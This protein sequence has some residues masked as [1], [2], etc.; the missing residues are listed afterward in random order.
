MVMENI[1]QGSRV[2]GFILLHYSFFIPVLLLC[3]WVGKR[4]LRNLTFASAPERIGFCISLGLGILSLIVV[5]IGQLGILYTYTFI[6]V[7]IFVVFVCRQECLDTVIGLRNGLRKI[8]IKRLKKRPT[9]ERT[10]YMFIIALF[11]FLSFVEYQRYI[12]EF[13]A[14]PLFPPITVDALIYHLANPKWYI[15]QHSLTPPWHLLIPVRAQTIQMFYTFGMLF[16]NDLVAQTFS[17]V[18]VFVTSLLLI[19]FGMRYFSK[20][21]GVG[22]ATMFLFSWIPYS[23]SFLAVTDWGVTMFSIAAIFALYN[24]LH[25]REERWLWFLGILLGFA[26]TSK[27]HAVITLFIVVLIVIGKMIYDKKISYLPILVIGFLLASGLWLARTVYYCGNLTSMSGDCQTINFTETAIG[28]P[29]RL[30]SIVSPL[31]PSNVI[32]V[33]NASNTNQMRNILAKSFD[34]FY[35]FIG[36]YFLPKADNANRIDYMPHY[37]LFFPFAVLWSKRNY[38]V[39]GLVAISTIFFL[40]M[41]SVSTDPRFVMP[42]L[43]ILGLAITYSV[44]QMLITNVPNLA[45]M[46]DN[47]PFL[48]LLLLALISQSGHTIKLNYEL[49]PTTPGQRH[50]VLEK[51]LEA[52]DA[53]M[54]MNDAKPN[55]YRVY[56]LNGSGMSYYVNGVALPRDV[57]QHD[58]KQIEHILTSSIVLFDFLKDLNVDFVLVNESLWMPD[59]PSPYPRFKAFEE[60]LFFK[61]H[62]K[63]V[64]KDVALDKDVFVYEVIR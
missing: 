15:E 36:R 14:R 51:N 37:L 58:P 27:Y 19:G 44:Q 11:A 22:A 23:F 9:L 2:I 1:R 26:F 20:I 52:Y 31:E 21:A 55:G 40:A 64:F 43:A 29:S 8:S 53:Y 28:V 50:Y 54:F 59:L 63:L 6:P 38:R 12:V 41:R 62:F 17:Y 35:Y 13:L 34:I 5:I 60:D 56:Q 16:A 33:S 18:F 47:K 30:L 25:S 39:L 3:Y 4:L 10:E 42:S 61:Q 24:W 32:Q 7:A 45:K 49:L 48:F 57:R 46:Q